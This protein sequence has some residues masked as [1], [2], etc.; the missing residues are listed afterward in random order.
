MLF[1]S[2]VELFTSSNEYLYSFVF[3]LVYSTVLYLSTDSHSILSYYLVNASA[4]DMD[5][6]QQQYTFSSLSVSRC[7]WLSYM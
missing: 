6:W 5:A 4:F 7:I 3:P 2:I 1:C